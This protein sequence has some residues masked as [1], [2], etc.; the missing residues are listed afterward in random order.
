[1]IREGLRYALRRMH[2]RIRQEL[3]KLEQNP[4]YEPEVITL[5]KQEISSIRIYTRFFES[6]RTTLKLPVRYSVNYEQEE[7][8][9]SIGGLLKTIS[10]YKKKG[11]TI[12]STSMKEI[13]RVDVE[14]N[15][16][17]LKNDL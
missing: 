1:M 12:N 8:D 4:D 2:I 10:E 3:K 9:N 5:S 11:G 16:D 17:E 15:R 6:M 14:F 7:K 13:K